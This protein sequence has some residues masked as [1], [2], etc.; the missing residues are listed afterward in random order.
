MAFQPFLSK[1]KEGGRRTDMN[2]TYIVSSVASSGSQEVC[3]HEQ[4]VVAEGK[5]VPIVIVHRVSYVGALMDIQVEGRRAQNHNANTVHTVRASANGVSCDTLNG[6][7]AEKKPGVNHMKLKVS[8]RTFV[9]PNLSIKLW[10]EKKNNMEKLV[11]ECIHSGLLPKNTVLPWVK[12]PR[13]WKGR[14]NQC[15]VVYMQLLI[16]ETQ[17]IITWDQEDS[18]TQ[19]SFYGKKWFF[20]PLENIHLFD[21]GVVPTTFFISHLSRNPCKK[22]IARIWNICG[23]RSKYDENSQSYLFYY[24]SAEKRKQLRRKAK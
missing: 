9:N 10:R 24:S 13:L 12:N 21:Q 19:E 8:N 22:T 15:K 16:F 7:Y 3:N 5:K 11:A 23:F 1:N 6:N 18:N 4:H 2:T 20:I 14:R 17:N